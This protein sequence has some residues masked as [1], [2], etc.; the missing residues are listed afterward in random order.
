MTTMVLGGLWH[1]ANWTFVVWGTIHG[2]W[3]A[4]HRALAR[5]LPSPGGWIPHLIKVFVTFQVVCVTWLFFRAESVGQAV[6]FLVSLGSGLVATDLTDLGFP[7][8]FFFALPMLLYELWV[9]R[10]GDL[11]AILAVPRAVRAL[12][13]IGIILYLV[14][15]PAP[16]A[17]EFIYFQ[18]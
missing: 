17:S 12:F 4:I 11:F 7:L 9:E 1:G 3:L 5:S 10:R 18:F 8:L 16:V 2:G 15:F 13:Y 14:W 6:A